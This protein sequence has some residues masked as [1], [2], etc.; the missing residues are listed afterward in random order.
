[1]PAAID[2]IQ[3]EVNAGGVAQTHHG[4][5]RRAGQY[6]DNNPGQMN[7]AMNS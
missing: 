1:M 2:D 5:E 7:K 6:P 4:F 3:C